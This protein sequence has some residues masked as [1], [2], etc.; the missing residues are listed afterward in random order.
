VLLCSIV[1]SNAAFAGP[2]TIEIDTPHP[3]PTWALLQRELLRANSAACEA[4]YDRYFDDRG[5]LLCVERWGGNDGPDD[6]IENLLHWP[7]L[8]ALGGSDKVLEL[9]KRAWE[10]HLRQYTLA[11]TVEVPFARDGMYYKEFPV[12]FDWLH[13]S[14]GLTVFNLQGL[15]DPY[16]RAFGQRAR[17][18]A[19][20]YMNEDPAAPNYDPKHKIIRSMINGSRGPMLRKA[21]GLDW[22]GDPIEVEGRFQPR[23]GEHNY[24]QFLEHFK[25]YNDVAGDH[26]QNLSAT[27]LALNA[28]MLAGERKYRDW[29]LEYVDAWRERMAANDGIIPSNIGLN[30]KIGGETGGRWYGGVYGWGFTMLMPP[31]GTPT[32]RNNIHLAFDG[33]MNAYLLTGDDK[34]LDPWR[35]QMKKV[36]ANLRMIDGKPHYPHMYG[37]EGWYHYTPEPYNRGALELYYLSQRSEDRRAVGNNAWLDYLEG[38]RPAFAEDAVRRNLA[39]VRQMVHGFRTDASTPDTRLADDSMRFNPCS[40]ESL[41]ELAMGGLIGGKNRL[42]LHSRLRYFDADQRR[43]GLPE[44]VAALIEQMTA[45]AVTL[46]LVNVDAVEPHTV[47]IQGGSYAEHQLRDATLGSRSVPIN[48]SHFSVRLAA[49]SG[50]KLN[51]SMQRHANQPTWSFPWDRE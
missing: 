8:H 39:Q 3:P 51:L 31:K 7:I 15:S 18:Y 36:N 21:T 29:L 5:Y 13:N 11:K 40:V 2:P 47:V 38:R 9:Y 34:Y 50:V 14:E 30:G 4:F 10:G 28:Y 19:G 46:S 33:F 20:F 37:S 6:A 24:Q 35:Q 22:A 27:G 43:A 45:D 44:G 42:V 41:V 49:G 32:H 23:H 1:L 12:M 16:D 48:N 17:R 25:D 26:P